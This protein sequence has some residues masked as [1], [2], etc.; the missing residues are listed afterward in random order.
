MDV[1]VT[2]SATLP[3]RLTVIGAFPSSGAGP[4]LRV[5]SPGASTTDKPSAVGARDAPRPRFDVANR[6]WV[7][8]DDLRVEL[9][10]GAPDEV[11]DV[12]KLR[13][14]DQQST[15]LLQQLNRLLR[16]YRATLQDGSIF[17]VTRPQ[18]SPF[19]FSDGAGQKWADDLLFEPTRIVHSGDL[20][21]QERRARLLTG[22]A[23]GGEPEVADLALVDAVAAF[24]S[25]RF[26]EAVLLCWSAIDATFTRRFEQ[27]VDER[28][29]DDWGEARKFLKGIDF[30]LRHKMT[31]GLRLLTG[32]SFYDLPGNFW[33]RLSESYRARN[34]I[35]H[36]GATATEDE[37]RRSIDVARELVKA[38]REL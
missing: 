36:E 20:S 12:D 25:G 15:R 33:D 37:S 5:V 9:D 1:V 4:V 7:R 38:V 26:R 14:Q 24:N 13:L 17:E 18:I 22:F 21:Q 11:T 16:W 34:R 19:V 28:L 31:T 3:F 6:R 27:L 23:T 32:R 30:G 8:P 29:G 2:V 35:I 10:F